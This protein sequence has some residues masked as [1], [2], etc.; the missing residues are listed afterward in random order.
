M[1]LFSYILVNDY[2]TMHSLL[3]G[4]RHIVPTSRPA[5]SVGI[6]VITS[7]LVYDVLA[8]IAVMF[9][10]AR[11]DEALADVF[12]ELQHPLSIPEIHY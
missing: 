4:P 9:V 2:Y 1:E 7:L 8:D 6:S 10:P 3:P 12:I 11:I 5:L